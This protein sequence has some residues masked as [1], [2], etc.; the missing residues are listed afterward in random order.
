MSS[1]AL[2]TQIPR[3]ESW[4][5]RTAHNPEG[6]EETTTSAHIPDIKEACLMYSVPSGHKNLGVVRGR[7][8]RVSACSQSWK[9]VARR[10]TDSR[11]KTNFSALRNPPEALRTQTQEQSGTEP[12]RVLNEPGTEP[13]TQLSLPI[14]HWEKA[15]L[16]LC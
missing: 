6:S 12:F 13:V 16:Q 7:T 15:S 2:Y 9:P 10:A 3:R 4:T 5:L 8:L 11:G 1:T 14:S